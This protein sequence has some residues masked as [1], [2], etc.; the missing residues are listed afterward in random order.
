MTKKRITITLPDEEMKL[1]RE[2]A[3]SHGTT[4]GGVVHEGVKLMMKQEFDYKKT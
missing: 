4:M 2:Q 1:L 3:Q